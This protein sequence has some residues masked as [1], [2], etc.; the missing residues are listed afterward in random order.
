MVLYDPVW[1][2]SWGFKGCHVAIQKIGIVQWFSLT[3]QTW[4]STIAMFNRKI[5]DLHH[6]YIYIYIH[7]L[8]TIFPGLFLLSVWSKG[9]WRLPAPAGHE[10][11]APGSAGARNSTVAVYRWL[12]TGQET[13]MTHGV[14]KRLQQSQYGWKLWKNGRWTSLKS[15]PCFNLSPRHK[16]TGTKSTRNHDPGP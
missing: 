10:R 8:C 3:F 13:L 4:Q 2:C 1:F 16:S 9:E 11:H 15:A 14:C 5:I 7:H 12:K 6:I